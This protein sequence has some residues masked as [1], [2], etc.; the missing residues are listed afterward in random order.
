MFTIARIARI[1]LTLALA[2]ALMCVVCM[3]AHR[4]DQAFQLARVPCY[5]RPVVLLSRADDCDIV[6]W[7]SVN[8]TFDIVRWCWW[9]YSFTSSAHTTLPLPPLQHTERRKLEEINDEN[10]SVISALLRPSLDSHIVLNEMMMLACVRIKK[11]S[12]FHQ[13]NH[14]TETLLY[15]IIHNIHLKRE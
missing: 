15:D 4:P 2:R 8:S 14:S 10:F 6:P 1:A 13:P 3:F 12:N 7:I 9:Q 11:K 5:T